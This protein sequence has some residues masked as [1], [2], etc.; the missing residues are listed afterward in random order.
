MVSSQYYDNFIENFVNVNNKIRELG[1]LHKQIG[2]NNNN[3]FYGR[4]GMNPERLEEEIVNKLEDK[5]YEKIVEKNGIFIGYL[6]K[7][8]N[9]S[10]VLIS[11]AITAKARI[12]LY[13]GLLEVINIGGRILYTDTDSIIASFKKKNYKNVIDK[14][15]GEVF[16]DSNKEDTII[17]DG[18]FAMPKTYALK[19]QN[20][21][22]IV[23]IKGFNT[24]PTFEE[25]KK[26]FYEKKT[27]TTE[28]TE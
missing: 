23:K 22:E 2:K 20:G 11:A 12:K 25:F 24:T 17:E 16:F 9:I 21:T 19:Y 7:E 18:V 27:I 3:A 14:N 8:K 5:K 4:L 1:P 13:K 15:L 10:N 26:T 28:N 6:K